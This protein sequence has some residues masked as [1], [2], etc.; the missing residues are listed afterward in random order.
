MPKHRKIRCYQSPTG[1]RQPKCRKMTSLMCLPCQQALSFYDKVKTANS[2]SRI[3]RRRQA[4]ELTR[5]LRAENYSD[6]CAT[7][8]A[9]EE[10]LKQHNKTLEE[11]GNDQQAIFNDVVAKEKE[12]VNRQVQVAA[13]LTVELL[14]CPWSGLAQLQQLMT[15]SVTADVSPATPALI[16][17]GSP[18]TTPSFH[19]G[20]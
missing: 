3:R 16:A 19:C 7:N 20:D 2:V 4:A 18:D 13:D 6:L 9:L 10:E 17:P 12:L 14:Q 11:L 5:L 15:T 1:V 8:M